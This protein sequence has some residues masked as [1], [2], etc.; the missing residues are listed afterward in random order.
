VTWFDRVLDAVQT[1]AVMGERVERLGHSVAGMAAELR[2]LDR[3]VARVE[4][5]VAV[6]AGRPLPPEDD[7]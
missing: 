7:Y 5:A 4:G 6:S 2:R 3:R 1:A